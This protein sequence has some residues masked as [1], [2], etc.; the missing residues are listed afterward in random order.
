L[1]SRENG[2]DFVNTD[3][4]RELLEKIPVTLILFAFLGYLGHEYYIFENDLESPINQKIRQIENLKN[5][6]VKL[7]NRNKEM[8]LFVKNL[9]VKKLEVRRLTVELNNTKG[10][11]PETL[12]IPFIMKL[13]I[14]EAKKIGLSILSLKPAGS[15]DSEYYTE[16]S[17]VLQFRGIY[18]QLVIFLERLANVNQIL[19]VGSIDIKSSGMAGKKYA[20]LDGNIELKAYRYRGSKADN[21][22]APPPGAT[23][24]PGKA[25]P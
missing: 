20:F 11:I 15:V 22:G 14:T 5:E 4:L 10:M 19:K 12:D 6:T 3:T 7:N 21:I 18:A 23:A 1:N 8:T 16:Q 17:F 13:V 25:G 9:D 2:D 24:P